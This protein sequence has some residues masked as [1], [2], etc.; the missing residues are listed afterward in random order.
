[1]AKSCLTSTAAFGKILQ[2]FSLDKNQK[3]Y[4][5]HFMGE[6]TTGSG[7]EKTEQTAEKPPVGPIA[8][9]LIRRGNWREAQQSG[10]EDAMANLKK[11]V[12]TPAV[13]GPSSQPPSSSPPAAKGPSGPSK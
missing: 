7:P 1:M 5:C 12:N 3:K 2:D 10:V 6:G 11:I 4:Y 8:G 9:V 13:R